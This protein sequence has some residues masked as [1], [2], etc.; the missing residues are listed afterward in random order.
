MKALACGMGNYQ[1]GAGRAFARA[2]DLADEREYSK[3]KA[4]AL[5]KL[6]Q[7]V[8]NAA[9]N[10]WSQ[11]PA[12][13]G[14]F[15]VNKMQND[16]RLFG[17]SQIGDGIRDFSVVSPHLKAVC[18][19]HDDDMLRLLWWGQNEESKKTLMSKDIKLQFDPQARTCS[20]PSEKEGEDPQDPGEHVAGFIVA[21]LRELHRPQQ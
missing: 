15:H 21:K 11:E 6:V 9:A 1:E 2:L 18:L 10:A 20:V 17:L 8:Y 19:T 3:R 13:N 14:R 5:E 12:V 16:G 4:E 7:D